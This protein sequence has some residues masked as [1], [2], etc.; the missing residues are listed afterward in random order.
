MPSVR[1]IAVPPGEAPLEV[2][3]AWVGLV[4][5]ID[6]RFG[7]LPVRVPVFGVRTAP[8]S[9]LAR[10]WAMITGGARLV[11]G[12]VLDPQRCVDILEDHDRK[13]AM[14]WRDYAPHMLKKG[15]RFVFPANVCEVVFE[16]PPEGPRLK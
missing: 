6:E 11:D 13:A 12:Y 2:R 4:L 8:T 14:W 7:G 10:M 16:A 5:P 15:K 9:M 3:Q 1:I